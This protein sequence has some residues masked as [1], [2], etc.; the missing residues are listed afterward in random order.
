MHNKSTLSNTTYFFL[1]IL[2]VIII[3]VIDVW[4]NWIRLADNLHWLQF[5]IFTDGYQTPIIETTL[6]ELAKVYRDLSEGRR[7][8]ID[9]PW[10]YLVPRQDGLVGVWQWRGRRQAQEELVL[11]LGEVLERHS[12]LHFEVLANAA[13]HG[14]KRAA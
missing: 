13:H 11:V 1:H 14:R 3:L 5:T 10:V 12:Q 7:E 9:V 2:L 8:L 4:E 6:P